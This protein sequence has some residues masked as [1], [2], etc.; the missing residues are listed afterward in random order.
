MKSARDYYLDEN[1]NCAEATIRGANDSLGLGLSG[2]AMKLL[3][4]CGGGMSSGMTCGVLCGCVAA[5]GSMLTEEKGHL[6]PRL[7]PGVS[8]FVKLFAETFGATDCR[9]LQPVY[10]RDGIRCAIL[11][12][13]AQE[14]FNKYVE[15]NGFAK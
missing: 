5:L 1:Y 14:L 2:E 3:S 15:E 8:G 9:D 12:E 4:G 6:S 13:Q 10:K 7:K 11:V